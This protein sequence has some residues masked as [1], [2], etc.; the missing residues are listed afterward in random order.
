MNMSTR[1]LAVFLAT[2][3]ACTIE[4]SVYVT[5][6]GGDSGDVV[7]PATDEGG[8]TSTGTEGATSQSGESSST[9]GGEVQCDINVDDPLDVRDDG[10]LS[11]C[12]TSETFTC[13]TCEWWCTTAGFSGCAGV[14]ADP[15]CPPADGEASDLCK[16]DGASIG[17]PFRCLCAP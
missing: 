7:D 9:D 10:T 17:E 5:T 15:A 11:P 14:L 4:G 8:S 3:C 13:T 16:L 6:G 2:L 12:Y 1:T